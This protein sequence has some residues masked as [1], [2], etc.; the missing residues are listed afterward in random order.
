L[1][2]LARDVFK[3]G[4]LSCSFRSS[5]GGF[6]TKIHA[7]SDDPR[8][9]IGFI[10]TSGKTSDYNAAIALL[11]VPGNEPKLFLNDKRCDGDFLPEELL[12]HGISP[13]SRRKRTENTHLPMT[14]RATRTET[15]S[16]G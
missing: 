6:T 10:V 12:I 16:D 2:R 8:R 11:F 14:S 15:V 9:A 13:L 7:R 5:R 3:G 1:P 4:I